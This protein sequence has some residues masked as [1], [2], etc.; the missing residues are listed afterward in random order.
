M[1]P[2]YKELLYDNSLTPNER[3]VYSYLIY[4]SITYIDSAF[5]SDGSELDINVITETLE[6][7]RYIAMHKISYRKLADE[8][9]MS[10]RSIIDILSDFKFIGIIDGDDIH[11]PPSIVNGGYFPLHFRNGLNGKL[12][13]FYS[14]IKN[15]SEQF[16]GQIDTFKW[17]LAEEFH[18][19]K[20]AIT[21]M[22]NRLYRKG[23]AER[24]NNGKLKIN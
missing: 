15:K 10:P 22:L 1:I 21:N 12:L 4:K 6:N 17:K 8:L 23:F 7:E 13:I 24:L 3:I 2:F 11:V 5:T 14:Y 9:C 18:T 16:G 20:I 19:T